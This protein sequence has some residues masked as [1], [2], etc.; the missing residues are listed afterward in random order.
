MKGGNGGIDRS[1]ALQ[2]QPGER[3]R[4]RESQSR[5]WACSLRQAW[6]SVSEASERTRLHLASRLRSQPGKQQQQQTGG[7]RCRHTRRGQEETD[8]SCPPGAGLWRML[9]TGSTGA[10]GTVCTSEEPCMPPRERSCA[11]LPLPRTGQRAECLSLLP[12]LIPPGRSVEGATAVLDCRP[13]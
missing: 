10:C 4:P 11:A 5:P 9:Q 12:G 3:T 1:C 7:R 2:G 13:G 6:A 8:E